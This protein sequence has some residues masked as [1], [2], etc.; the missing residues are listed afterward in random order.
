MGIACLKFLSV[1]FV[2]MIAGRL[3]KKI[4]SKFFIQ[5]IALY[6]PANCTESL[7]MSLKVC[8][9]QNSLKGKVSKRH[10]MTPRYCYMVCILSSSTCLYPKSIYLVK[11]SF[12]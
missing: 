6:V 1:L 11:P 9:S 4:A 3:C 7:E 2:N 10:K 5:L 8:V 12:L